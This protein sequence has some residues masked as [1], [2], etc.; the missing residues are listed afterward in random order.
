MPRFVTALVM[1]L[2]MT[3]SLSPLA[4][5]P[6][7]KARRL[8]DV[9]QGEMM[10]K[11]ILEAITPQIMNLAVRSNPDLSPAQK[12]KVIDV[13]SEEFDAAVPDF[14][15]SSAQTYAKHFSEDELDDAIAFYESP[16]GQR[17]QELLPTIMQESMANGQAIGIRVTQGAV[18]RLQADGTL[19]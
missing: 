1:G 19:P 16:T 13:V 8:V 12:D 11:Q 3:G 17:F 15:E 5:D 9:S 14:L 18:E 10:T 7:E 6:L 2:T 4:A